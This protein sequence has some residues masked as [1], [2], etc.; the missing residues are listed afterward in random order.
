MT[1]KEFGTAYENGCTRTV[2][3]LLSRGLSED[4]AKET[5]QAAWVRGWERR[6]QIRDSERTLT[7]VNSIALNLYRSQKRRDHRL[8]EMQEFPV[9]PSVSLLAIDVKRML[10]RCR[11]SERELL[12]KRYFYGYE[13]EELAI[14]QGCSETA[15]RVRLL[16]ARRHLRHI[17]EERRPVSENYFKEIGKPDPAGG[18]EEG[19]WPYHRRLPGLHL[20]R[21]ISSN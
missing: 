1:R 19:P 4:E 14:E 6:N 7:W 2:R 12:E 3:F 9:P 8:G 15:V 13:I 10:Q 17:F 16:R 18:W 21:V 20:Q 5:A 11:N